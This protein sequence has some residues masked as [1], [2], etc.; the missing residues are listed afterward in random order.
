MAS[1]KPQV[2]RATPMVVA[3]LALANI[4]ACRYSSYEGDGDFTDNGVLSY[5]SR[6]VLDLG[7]LDLEKANSRRYRLTKLPTAEF[8]IGI[9]LVEMAPNRLAGPRPDHRAR[10]RVQLESS[11]GETII[12]Q[13]VRLE[14]WVWSHGEGDA[15]SRLYLRGETRDVQAGSSTQPTRVNEGPSGGW[16]T[17]FNSSDSESY[18][19][20]VDVLEPISVAGRPARLTLV[21]WGQT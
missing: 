4:C 12:D 19:L 18:T 3:F 5:S 14:N 16:G 11:Q 21:G 7:P 8:V 17:Y 15:K 10:V 2:N 9:D 13:D 20:S 6:Y 1:V